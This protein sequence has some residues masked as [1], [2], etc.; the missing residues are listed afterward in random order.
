MQVI[1][2]N[3]PSLAKDFIQANV[4]MNKNN[5][6]YIRPLDNEV[7]DVFD[8][9]KNKNYQ[10]GETKRWIL[11][12][13]NGA[14]AGRIAAFTNTKYVNHGTDF[15]TG[16]VG[17]FDCINNQ[18]AANLL[19]DKAAEWL[20]SKG[21]EAMDGPINFGDRDKW[22]GLMVEGFEKEPIYGMSYNPPYYEA[23]FESYGFLNFYNQYYYA[24]NVTDTLPCF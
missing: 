16:G 13:D 24:M 22:W 14:L 6:R 17:F 5:P 11:K 7:N 1:E 20:R 3:T 9:N 18:A 12:D 15:P 2:V 19:F 21:M 23:L 8:V 4:L 10:Y